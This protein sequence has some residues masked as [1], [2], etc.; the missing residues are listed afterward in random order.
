MEKPLIFSLHQ[1]KTVLKKGLKNSFNNIVSNH[2]IHTLKLL[3]TDR[4]N[5]LFGQ[6]HTRKNNGRN[7]SHTRKFITKTKYLKKHTT[8]IILAFLSELI[9]Q[10]P[11]PELSYPNMMQ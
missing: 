2:W 4:L 7:T 5:I 10:I 6:I 8:N 1:T 9:S 11:T 3:T